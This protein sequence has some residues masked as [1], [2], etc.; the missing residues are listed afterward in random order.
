MA[1][2]YFTKLQSESETVGFDCGNCSINELVAKS[3]YP[4]ILQHAFAYRVS[5]ETKTLGYYMLEF[6][7]ISLEMCPEYVSEYVSS[8]QSYC[9]AVHVRYIAIA[10]EY[11]GL[12]I[13]SAVLQ[14]IAGCVMKLC[15]KWSIRLITLDALKDK[16]Q[17]YRQRGVM[18]FDEHEL[19]NSSETIRMYRECIL[20]R[21]LIEN[22]ADAAL[23][24]V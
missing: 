11:Q 19:A 5:S 20:D 21:N 17:W 15:S 6:E 16:Y 3:Y 24:E 9:T 13:G 23:N 7:N 4:T 14:Y 22:Y 12:H 8:I 10:K 2:L 1:E 18:A